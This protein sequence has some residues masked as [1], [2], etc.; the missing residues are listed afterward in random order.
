MLKHYLGSQ[1]SQR[2]EPI[3]FPNYS[4]RVPQK[5]DQR[6]Y[7]L[8]KLTSYLR[9][10]PLQANA[11]LEVTSER[12][13]KLYQ[14]LLTAGGAINHGDCEAHQCRQARDAAVAILRKT[15]RGLI[16][17]LGMLIAKDDPRWIIFNLNQPALRR[18][19]KGTKTHSETS[20]AASPLA[21]RE[22]VATND[23]TASAPTATHEP[24]CELMDTDH[25]AV[26][27]RPT[28]DL[29]KL[30]DNSALLPLDLAD[31]IAPHRLLAVLA[32]S[33]RPVRKKSFFDWFFPSLN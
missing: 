22:P 13:G 20:P 30:R 14:E 9:A 33:A 16:R 6:L 27:G 19:H 26:V 32:F 29:V 23:Q 12:A 8:Q 2:W 1:C 18:R 28:L 15:M 17:E 4:L 3:G 5:V 21:A 10:N 31:R 11:Q 24:T 7:V 25:D